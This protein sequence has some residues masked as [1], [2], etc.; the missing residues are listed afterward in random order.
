VWWFMYSR[1]CRMVILK[2]LMRHQ[3]HLRNWYSAQLW[4]RKWVSCCLSLSLWAY[5]RAVDIISLGG[6]PLRVEVQWRL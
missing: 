4:R 1:V 5:A 2:D 6:R 3:G